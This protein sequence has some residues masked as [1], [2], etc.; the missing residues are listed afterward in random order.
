MIKCED[1][2]RLFGS[3]IKI[4]LPILLMLIL[5]SCSSAEK[6]V[7]TDDF[8]VDYYTTGGFTNVTQGITINSSGW[9]KSWQAEY[10]SDKKILDSVK[11]ETELLNE[12][13][14]LLED[15]RCFTYKNNFAGNLTAYLQIKKNNNANQI[16][17]NSFDLPANMP[18]SLK[19]LIKISQ[20]IHFK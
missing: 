3:C 9:A 16:S 12:I 2:L 1:K 11:V 18:R 14:S 17:F 7:K 4:F 8:Q 13:N 5:Q 20:S 10:Q 15:Q 6:S 19:E